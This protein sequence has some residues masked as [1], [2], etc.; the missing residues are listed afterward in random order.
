M[1]LLLQDFRYGIRMLLKSP[2]FTTIAIITLA[3]GIGANSAIFSI[4]N[5]L[6]LR[7]FPVRESRSF[8]PASRERGESKSQAECGVSS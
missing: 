4:A 7:P 3:L 6:L 5:A 2:A 8:G 1:G